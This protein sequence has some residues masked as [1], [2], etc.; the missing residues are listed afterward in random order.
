MTSST[1]PSEIF[2]LSDRAVD[3]LAADNP[4]E[5]TFSGVGGHDHRWPDLSPEGAAASVER[6]R[7]LRAQAL[8]LEA[9]GR[10]TSENDQLACRVLVD[11]CDNAIAAHEANL[12]LTNLNNIDSPHQQLRQIEAVIEQGTTAAGPSSSFE[13]LRH[14]LAAAEVDQGAVGE[15][16]DR[17][18]GTARAAFGQLNQW[19][20]DVYLPDARSADGVGEERYAASSRLFLGTDLDLRATYR[21]GWDEVERLWAELHAV[22]AR[23]DADQS[24]GGV[25]ELLTTDPE[26]SAASVGEFIALMQQR[27]ETALANLEGTNFDV[28]AE[29]RRIEVKVEPAGGALAA[30]YVPPSEDL[31][32]PGSVWYPIEGREHIPLFREITIAHHEGFPGHHLQVGV[33]T[34][35]KDE[36]SRFHRLMVWYSGSGEGWALYAEQLMG[37]L[38]YLEQPDYEAGLL[39]SQM[40]RALRVV[41]DIGVH[42]DL[43]IPDDVSFHPGAMWSYDLAYELLV[44][45]AGEEPAA[46]ASEVT[47]YF[48]WPGQATSYKVGE[49]AILD[50]RAEHRQ[51]PDFDE[52][53]F[54]AEV[55]AVG[56]VGL[57]LLRQQLA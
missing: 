46:A 54:H 12:H 34:T 14:R 26:R 10:V 25:F 21:W 15:R 49:Q 56:S 9:E 40:L 30:H 19:L 29:I 51:R 24:I 17:A 18:I 20:L 53:S 38:G 23:I 32:R 16:L 36:L 5:A 3:V 50:L 39:S 4:L 13:A 48:G 57:D 35:L 8:G 7:Q 55:L 6:H 2:S 28:P 22:C 43:P 1:D 41:I 11:H 44:T 31:S 42:L 52:K 47:R 33:Q 27:Q 37:E 45:R